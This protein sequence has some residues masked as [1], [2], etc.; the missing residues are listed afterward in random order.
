MMYDIMVTIHNS[1]N[2]VR[3]WGYLI[4]SESKEQAVAQALE[5]A[6]KKANAPYSRFK[7]CTFSVNDEDVREKPNW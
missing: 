6:Q 2:K 3:G 7:K 5:N 4:R 1:P